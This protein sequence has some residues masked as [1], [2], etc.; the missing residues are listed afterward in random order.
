MEQAKKPIFTM[1]LM[2]TGNLLGA[3]ILALPVNLGPA[4]M[5]P[6]S[7]GIMLVWGL[8][9]YSS[10]VLADQ[11]ELLTGGTGGL[12]SFFG[13]KLG[14]SAKWVAV[15]ADLIV[16]YGVL[17]AYLTGTTSILFELFKIPLPESVVCLGYFA[18]VAGLTG[19]GMGLLR[20]CNVFILAGMGVTFLAMIAMTTGHMEPDRALPMQ[21]RFLPA[22]MPV[23]LTAFLYHNLVPTVCREL[24]CDRAAIR[25]AMFIGSAIG[26]AMNLIWTV[27]V[28]CSLPFSEPESVSILSAFEHNLPATIPL[29]K[30]LGSRLFTDIGLVFAVL[31]MT[32][33]F[34]A[35]GAALRGFLLDLTDT[36]LDSRSNALIW[37]LAFIP[38][39]LVSLFYPD[40]FLQAMN[41]VG[42]VGVCVLFGILPS[43]VLLRQAGDD[44]RTR[45]LA[46]LMFAF[47]GLILIFSVGQE[48]G[49]TH[50]QP[51]VKYWMGKG[52]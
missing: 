50:I 20:R 47:F 16:F 31:S 45:R 44:R 29:S 7:I 8:M 21:W 15:T 3:G 10:F 14:T 40:I 12:P 5:I 9:L 13:A 38:P 17:T 11:K 32:A 19:M 33:A 24:H 51:N 42:G 30:L 28:F 2:V 36:H 6:S 18:V 25:K 27:A 22:A 39:L 35:N 26:L 49:L 1:S 23:V 46:W 37:I 52:M 34:M 41:L 48:L 4:G 43:L